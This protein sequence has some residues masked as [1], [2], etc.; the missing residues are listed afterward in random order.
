MNVIQTL[1]ML[2][3]IQKNPMSILSQRFNIP[4]GVNV[5]DPNEI[6]NHLVNSGQV[7]Q[8]DVNAIKNQL[9]GFDFHT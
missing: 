6:I 5:K 3:Q 1:G 9:S 8:S 2:Q 4:D 7:K